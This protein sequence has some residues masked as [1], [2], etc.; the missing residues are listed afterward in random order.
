M[1]IHEIISLSILGIGLI[2]IGYMIWKKQMI[3]VLHYYHRSKLKAED[4][5]M[6]CKF[7]G[8]G[9]IICGIGCIQYPY[10]KYF[11]SY[12][13]SVVTFWIMIITGICCMIYSQFKYNKGIF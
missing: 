3:W 1:N 7:M 13:L 5:T 9:S 4:K 2:Y 11:V 10:L 8:I 6:Y 12:Y